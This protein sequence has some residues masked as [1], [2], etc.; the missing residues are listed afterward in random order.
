MDI[1]INRWIDGRMDKWVDRR[2]IDRE[3]D[4]QNTQM[5]GQMD[6]EIEE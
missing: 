3:M 2:W 6:A 5:S 4:G 1:W